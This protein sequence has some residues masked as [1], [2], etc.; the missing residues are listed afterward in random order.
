MKA[1]LSFLT[2]STFLLALHLAVSSAGAQT[3]DRAT[4]NGKVVDETGGALPGVSVTGRSPALQLRE[5]SV[6]T[7]ADGS[8]LIRDLPPGTYQVTFEL[9]GF[10]TVTQ[11]AIRLTAGFTGKVDV[12]MKLGSLEED[13]TVSGQSPI[14]DVTSTTV[15]T[16]LVREVL[17]TIPTGKG[18]GDVIAMAPGVRYAGVIDVGG[19]RIANF[20]DG[21]TNFGS[22]RQTPRLEGK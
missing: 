4:I 8:Y 15:S 2:R 20:G 18:F 6:V 13:I 17:D 16:S 10:Q 5:V 1:R 14:V 12:T 7:E 3:F 9:R 19:S 11:T 22:T 21:G